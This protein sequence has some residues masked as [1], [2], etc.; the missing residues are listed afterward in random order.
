MTTTRTLSRPIHLQWWW[1]AALLLT[2][3]V[4][5]YVFFVRSRSGQWADQAAFNVFVELWPRAQWPNFLHEFLDQL[6]LLCGIISAVFLLYRVVRDRSFLRASLAVVAVAA[7][8]ITTQVFK[9]W[10]LDRPDFNFGTT[11]NSLPSGHTT[12][13]AAAMGLMYVIA[14]PRLRPV[15]QPLAWGFT[16]TTGLAT[17]ICGWH[18]PSDIAV[19]MMVAA[20]WL[21]LS[22]ALLQRHQPL[23]SAETITTWSRTTGLV[24]LALWAAVILLS[25]L[26]PHPH[27]QKIPQLLQVTYGVLGVV[28][29][30]AGSLV[31]ALCLR[32]VVLGP[33][34]S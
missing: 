21:V 8:L 28:H 12:A 24:S 11:Q 27:I 6:P 9:H 30:L 10:I 16:A 14:P 22:V 31:A 25:F 34:R 3:S 23:G 19:G 7:A 5:E 29:I 15:V 33:R 17:L 4:V 32:S 20:F 1:A 26:L 18:R 2:M 13:A